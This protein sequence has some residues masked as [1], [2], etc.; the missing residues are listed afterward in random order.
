[1]RDYE[2]VALFPTGEG[3]DLNAALV[4]RVATLVGDHGGKMTEVHHWGRRRFAYPIRK[5]REGYYVLFKFKLE[6][7]RAAGLE[8]AIR[9]EREILRHLTVHDEGGVGAAARPAAAG[10]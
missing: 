9:L 7:E 6:A 8:N 10:A 5:L 2:M 1:M 3:E 4:E